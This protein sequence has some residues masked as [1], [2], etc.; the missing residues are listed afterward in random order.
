MGVVNNDMFV[1]PL[2]KGIHPQTYIMQILEYR[3]NLKNMSRTIRQYVFDIKNLL[4]SNFGRDG[5]L[6]ENS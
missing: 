1:F 5:K 4:R 2:C 3:K 6:S